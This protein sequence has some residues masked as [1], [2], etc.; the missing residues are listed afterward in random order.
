MEIAAI[1]GLAA[2]LAIAGSLLDLRLRRRHG[3]GAEAS[4][5]DPVR[6]WA[7]FALVLA[8]GTLVVGLVLEA[9]PALAPIAGVV[10]VVL[11]AGGF[12]ALLRSPRTR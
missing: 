10:G 11:M 6:S 3:S 8:G 5:A 12:G 2:V 9:Q 7:A 4:R 1:I